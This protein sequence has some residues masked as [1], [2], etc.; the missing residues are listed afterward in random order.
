MKI[1]KD[2]QLTQEVTT[3]N[4]DSVLA[5]ESKTY[6]FYAFNELHVR[7]ENLEFSVEHKEVEVLD[8]PKKLQAKEI[9]TILI[10]WSPS[11]TLKKGLKAELKIKGFEIYEPED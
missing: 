6:E 5:G 7:V 2:K 4:L 8:Y 1:F 10:K 9:G 11:I 3:L